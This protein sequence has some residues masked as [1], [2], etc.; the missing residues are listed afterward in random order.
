MS[1]GSFALRNRLQV[2]LAC[3]VI[4]VECPSGSG[5]LHSAE[6][7][8]KEGLPLWVVPADT[9]RASAEGSNGLLA[10]GAAPLTRP[11]ELLRFLGPGPLKP[12]ATSKDTPPVSP[13]E[14][15]PPVAQ[16]LLAALGHGASM[17]ELC[18]ALEC[19]S[20]E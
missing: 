1:R 7:A 13:G 9:D 11:E 16:R 2:S 8:W 18:A 19:T 14:G 10:R 20:Q 12:P 3:A 17:E 6:L 15:R 4:L 5:A